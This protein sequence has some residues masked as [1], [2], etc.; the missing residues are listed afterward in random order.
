MQALSLAVSAEEWPHEDPTSPLNG[1]TGP[2]HETWLEFLS[3]VCLLQR[4]DMRA[5]DLTPEQSL[6]LYLN[7][8]HCLLIHAQLAVGPPSS[9]F[10][11]SG[12]FTTC[13]YEAFSDLISLAELEHCILKAGKCVSPSY[14][15]LILSIF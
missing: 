12:F 11:W 10:K 2:A 15:S 13:S 5:A 1:L 8:Y 7:L 3:G 4:V 14:Q 6:A 9:F